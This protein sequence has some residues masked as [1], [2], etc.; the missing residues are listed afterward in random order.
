MSKKRKKKKK[1]AT[2]KKVLKKIAKLESKKAVDTA[3]RVIT[4]EVKILPDEPVTYLE[5]NIGLARKTNQDAC[6]CMSLNFMECDKSGKA[7]LLVVADGMGGEAEGDKASILAVH[8]LAHT[9]VQSMI[10]TSLY[11]TRDLLPDEKAEALTQILVQG[12]QS[13]HLAI[14]QYADEDPERRGMGTTMTA[15]LVSGSILAIAHVGDSR[16]YLL[17]HTLRLLTRDHSLAA[18]MIS[19]GQINEE[20]T[21]KLPHRHMLTRALGSG[22]IPRIDTD[23]IN[24]KGGERLLLCS[25]G[26]WDYVGDDEILRLSGEIAGEKELGHRLVK[27]AL[28]RGGKDNC[29]VVLSRIHKM[30]DEKEEIE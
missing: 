18:E 28:E 13:A 11:E 4:R 24:L 5:T 30:E 2:P 16:A 1:R 7:Y 10:P 20:D 19:S 9:V 23:V 12:F 29:T 26:L 22:D 21:E 14:K 6:L 25:D 17:D 27:L 8:N 15:A 3:P